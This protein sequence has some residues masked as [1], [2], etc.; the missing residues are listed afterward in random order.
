MK[1]IPIVVVMPRSQAHLRGEEVDVVNQ[2][3]C[4]AAGIGRK[5]SI[6][7]QQ[8]IHPAVRLRR[9]QIPERPELRE[10]EVVLDDERT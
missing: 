4:M 3:S 9:L 7:P 6:Q 5:P 2:E 1:V 10:V 8:E